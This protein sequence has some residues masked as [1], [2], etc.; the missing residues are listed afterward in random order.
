MPSSESG[1][2]EH[3]TGKCQLRSYVKVKQYD[4]NLSGEDGEINGDSSDEQYNNKNSKTIYSKKNNNISK[5]REYYKEHRDNEKR[6]SKRSRRYSSDNDDND[7]YN[8]NRNHETPRYD[9]EDECYKSSRR[10]GD[11]NLSRENRKSYVDLDKP[12]YNDEHVH[13]ESESHRKRINN[14][15]R[16]YADKKYIN[17]SE[18][19]ST[20]SKHVKNSDADAVENNDLPE[21]TKKKTVEDIFSKAGGAYIPPSR[22]RQMQESIKDKSSMAY[23]RMAWEALKKS[24]VGLI[25][26]VNTSNIDDIVREMLSENIVRGRGLVSQ[27]I[28]RAQVASPSFTNVYAALVSIINIKFPNIGELILRRLIIQFRK[29]FKRNDKPVCINSVKFIG[30][31]VNQQVAHELLAL[32]ILTLMLNNHTGDSVEVAVSFLKDVGQKLTDVSPKG[33]NAV[34]ERLRNILHDSQTDKRV[35]YMIEVIFHI[36]RD[37]FQDFPSLLEGVDIPEE[38]Q[39]THLLRLDDTG[40]AE[41]ILNVFKLEPNFIENEEKYNQIKKDILGESSDDSSGNEDEDDDDDDDDE[42][43]E[44]EN[45]GGNAE[46][47]DKTET[48][49]VALRR[50]IYLTIR[51]SLDYEECAHK[52]MKLD[53]KDGQQ[54]EFCLMVVECCAQERSY[55]KFY[56]LLGQRF[57]LLRREFMEQFV[58]IFQEQYENCHHLETNKLRNTAKMFSHLLVSD[59]I[60]W[61]VLQVIKLNEVDTTSSSR[62]FIKILFQE[63]FGYFGIEMILKRLKDPSIAMCLEGV[64]PRDDPSNTR[65]AINFFTAIGLGVLTDDLRA[66]LK[67][68]PKVSTIAQKIAAAEHD[69]ASSDSSSSSDSSGSSDSS[70]SGSSDSDSNSDDGRKKKTEEKSH[71]RKKKERSPSLQRDTK[72]RKELPLQKDKKSRKEHHRK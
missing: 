56:G 26:K 60:P 53:I 20:S 36:R 67:S 52:M 70:S 15:E 14:E 7:D 66:H 30:H 57:C 33:M 18:E 49:L 51:S 71:H 44:E 21:D 16:R 59:G 61:T 64:F 3:S 40:N 4:K 65:F 35:Q 24:I 46:I 68:M 22:L 19:Q 29:S 23:Q 25:N 41:D 11:K 54:H 1:V 38:D 63:L 6:Y 55:E 13:F 27:S 37:N 17:S 45:K 28:I 69:L 12:I 2:S 8:R 58:I 31:L 5:K 50:R 47:I 39:I 32:E 9:D 48:N 72:S 42:D 43:N 62:I 10:E 34:F